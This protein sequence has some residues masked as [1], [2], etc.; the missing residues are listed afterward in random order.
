MYSNSQ[1][2]IPSYMENGQ[3]Q[4]NKA[5]EPPEYNSTFQGGMRGLMREDLPR[6]PSVSLSANPRYMGFG[7]IL[8]A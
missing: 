1:K 7:R 2:R 4:T 8:R 5:V 3:Y 6:I